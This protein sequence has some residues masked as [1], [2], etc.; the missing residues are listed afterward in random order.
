MSHE[1]DTERNGNRWWLVLLVI[2][3]IGTL[4]PPFYAHNTPTFIGMPFFYWYQF[5]WVI[6]TVVIT[7]VVYVMIP[8]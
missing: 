4:W 7:A 8:D 5:L 2:P 1:I 6:I 3:L